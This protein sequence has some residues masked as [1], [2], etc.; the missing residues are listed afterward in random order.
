MAG[1]AGFRPKSATYTRRLFQKPF[2]AS[3]GDAFDIPRG[4]DLAAII[5]EI[6]GTVTLSTAAT[7]VSEFGT[8]N[9]LASAQL[10]ADG[11]KRYAYRNGIMSCIGNF[12]MGLSR[13][14]V[15]PGTGIATHSIL[16]HHVIDLATYGGPRPKD[17]ALHTSIPYMSLL[18][19]NTQYG[20]LSDMWSNFGAG[21][22][23]ASNIVVNVY[24]EYYQERNPKDLTEQRYLRRVTPFTLKSANANSLL[25]F[26]LP[27]GTYLR[28]LKWQS[29]DLATAKP[30]SAA[31][32]N[33]V[34]VRAGTDVRRDLLSP[35][36][37]RG[38]NRREFE[39]G[40][41]LDT[42]TTLC[43]LD[44]LPPD[45]SLTDLWDLRGATDAWAEFDVAANT[46]IDG[47]VITYDY[48]PA[49][50]G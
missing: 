37:I 31:R 21:V 27:T 40:P 7:T 11:S 6:V 10:A 17:S 26:Q 45:G 36:V 34:R 2:V 14:L 23:S 24:G 28:G 50:G 20:A 1:S 41:L 38:I 4:D 48:Q 15:N 46:W 18:T 3:G 30:V 43:Y 13:E 9:L 33:T 44:L 12:E 19:L 25:Q 35:A 49:L 42:F 47:E 39:P 16:S 22:I 29:F 8:A 32:V 5:I